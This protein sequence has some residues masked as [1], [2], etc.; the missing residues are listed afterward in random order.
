MFNLAA[1]M[2]AAEPA[3]VRDIEVITDEILEAKRVGGEAILTIGKGLIE[4]KSMLTHGEWLSWLEEKVEFSE[5]SAQ[6][7]MR[8]AREWSNPTT[9][10]DLGASKALALL[11][12]PEGERDVFVEEPHLV[13]GEEK[14]VIDMSARELERAIREREEALADKRAAEEAR[15]KMEA[16]MNMVKSILEAAQ[17]DRDAALREVEAKRD[18]YDALERAAS[19]LTEQ[20]EELKNRPVEVAVEV[21]PA[22]IEAARAEAVAE[23]QAKLDK[24]KADVKLAREGRTKAEDAR[25]AAEDALA[26]AKADLDRAAEEHRAALEQ[27]DKRAALSGNEDL[28]LFRALF[29]QVQDQINRMAGV[30][31]KIRPK[32]PSS[33]EKLQRA[34][35]KLSDKVREA[36]Q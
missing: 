17:A 5:R 8:L 19:K 36:A 23:M 4:A 16:D 21:D 14:S 9:L 1:V 22:A 18:A 28:M 24:A 20:L 30:L 13:D 33:A 32:D 3:R 34:L 11:A 35:L 31:L 6:R 12:L 25:K 27:A 2:A 29:D 7:F 10:A 26:Q 15:A